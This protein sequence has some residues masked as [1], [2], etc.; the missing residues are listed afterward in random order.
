M[1]LGGGEELDEGERLEGNWW[2]VPLQPHTGA[3]GVLTSWEVSDADRRSQCFFVK[4]GMSENA[5]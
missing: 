1:L 3:M 2:K 4:T 5:Q